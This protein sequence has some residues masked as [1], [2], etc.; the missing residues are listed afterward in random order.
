MVSTEKLGTKTFASLFNTNHPFFAAPCYSSKRRESRVV[1]T[2]PV[3]N[4]ITHQGNEVRSKVPESAV[5]PQTG[6]TLLASTASR[7]QQLKRTVELERNTSA[8][9]ETAKESAIE[10][11]TSTTGPVDIR[12]QSTL[13]PI[14][15]GEKRRVY[16]ST[17]VY[18]RHR[19]GEASSPVSVLEVSMPPVKCSHYLSRPSQTSRAR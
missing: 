18:I 17:V 2:K 10:R 1:S 7:P 16:D 3:V 15:M 6:K 9:L 19:S 4:K 5:R 14:E 12:V 13:L 8:P 11:S